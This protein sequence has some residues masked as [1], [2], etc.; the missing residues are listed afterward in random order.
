MQCIM[1]IKMCGYGLRDCIVAIIWICRKAGSSAGSGTRPKPGGG[2]AG[3]WRFYTED[4]PG[5]K[6]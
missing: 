5:I 1:C 3:M 4:S 6:V 2:S